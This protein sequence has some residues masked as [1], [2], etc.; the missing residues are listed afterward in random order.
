[1][2]AGRFF[3]NYQRFIAQAGPYTSPLSQLNSSSRVLVATQ[4]IPLIPSEMLKLSWK[5]D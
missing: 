4:L 1:V 3:D 2:S 5:G